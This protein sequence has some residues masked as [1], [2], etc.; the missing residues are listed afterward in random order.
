MKCFRITQIN[1]I[2]VNESGRTEDVNE[3]VE[4]KEMS[5]TKWKSKGYI[6]FRIRNKV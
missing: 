3:C 6:M 5:E 4:R 1:I 2:I